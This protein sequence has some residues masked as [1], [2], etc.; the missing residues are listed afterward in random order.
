MIGDI[1]LANTLEEVQEI[2]KIQVEAE[3]AGGDHDGIQRILT[4]DMYSNPLR[5]IDELLQ[6][7]QDAARKAAKRTD[8]EFR[9][10][11]DKLEFSHSGKDFDLKDVI[12]ITGIGVS[13]KN[14]Q[15]IGTF[16]IGFKSVYQI[17]DEPHIYSGK[18]NFKIVEFRI[19]VSLPKHDNIQNTVIILPF[20]REYEQKKIIS[21][22]NKIE[23][24]SLL[25]LPNID[26]I[27]W[28]RHEEIQQIPCL[29]K[30]PLDQIDDDNLNYKKIQIKHISSEKSKQY[31]VFQRNIQIR[32][33]KLDIEIAFGLDPVEN[34]IIPL[35][36]R[37]L[38]VFFPTTEE[39]R[40]NFLLNAPFRTTANR[41]K[42]KL[43]NDD[44]HR[45]TEALSQLTADSILFIKKRFPDLLDVNFY[46]NLIPLKR[47]E[48]NHFYGVFFGAIKAL[49]KNPKNRLL[50]VQ[51]SAFGSANDVLL[52]ENSSLMELLNVGDNKQLFGKRYWVNSEITATKERTKD[53]HRY[54]R[55]HLDVEDIGFDKFAQVFTKIL[56]EKKN[57]EWITRLYR[58]LLTNQKQLWE[59]NPW[60]LNYWDNQTD[61][62]WKTKPIIR[63]SNGKHVAPYDKDGSPRAWLPSESE[64]Y[65]D[66]VKSALLENEEA[67]EFLIKIGLQ[68][69]DL[70]A[71]FKKFIAPSYEEDRP[72][73]KIEKY[74][75]DISMAI[76]TYREY[77]HRPDKKDELVSAIKSLYFIKAK[78]AGTGYKL[79]KKPDQVYLQT[80]ELA[81]R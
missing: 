66:T 65:F 33:N 59:K 67:K 17:T 64:S 11:N 4:E 68:K 5:F 15:D 2:R 53:I 43:E 30:I 57:D 80:K 21:Y 51:N 8:V 58:I 49:L 29:S 48:Q 16:G 10:H 37:T 26:S 18:Y 9:L 78:N 38:H 40:L 1:K 35:T 27:T 69:P 24:E 7:A 77:R 45:M 74:L 73:V 50:P 79:F 36:N 47:E 39:T 19:P 13:T 20:K 12:S 55:G 3:R 31:L 14:D 81:G 22:L 32:G 34:R 75:Q 71:E 62:I 76:E 72:S 23:I 46:S 28:H 63:L 52:A 60:E 44:D 56:I 6:N 61:G 41:E 25:F 70:L 54:L 42:I